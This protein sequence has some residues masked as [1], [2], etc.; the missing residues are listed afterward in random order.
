MLYGGELALL[1]RADGKEW[2]VCYAALIRVI[3]GHVTAKGRWMAG[4]SEF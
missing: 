2:I 4:G 3:G 1:L